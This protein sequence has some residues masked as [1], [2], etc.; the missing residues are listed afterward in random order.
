MVVFPL[1]IFDWAKLVKSNSC[2]PSGGINV[3]VERVSS[4][5]EQVGALLHVAVDSLKEEQAWAETVVEVVPI[6]CCL[7]SLRTI[8]VGVIAAGHGISPK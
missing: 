4:D 6:T 3:R 2:H 5:V 1:A 8:E 7:Q